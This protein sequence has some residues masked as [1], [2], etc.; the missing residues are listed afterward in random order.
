[1]AASREAHTK[2]YVND[3]YAGLYS[4]VES[5]DKD[6]LARNLGEDGGYLFEYDYPPEAAPYYFEDRGSDP[7]QYVPRPF[8]PQT[9]ETDPRPEFIVDLVQVINQS[10][11]ATFRTAIAEY[12]DLGKFLKHVAVEVFVADYDGFLGQWG[13]NNFNFYRH[14]NQKLFTFIPWDKSQA[15]LGGFTYSIFKNFNDVPS[16]Q[17][18]RLMSRVL[19]YQDLFNLYLDTL[20]DCV[21]SAEDPTGFSDGKGW[22]E[23][24]I[25]REYE[26]IREA[27]LADPDKPFSNAEF[28]QAVSDLGVFSRQRGEQVRREVNNS[29]PR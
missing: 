29:R 6:F 23:H 13:M 16:A 28:E 27:A 19:A 20:L 3:R 26:Q 17:R 22:L 24:E 18:N 4:I 21:T 2:L 11:D 7:A 14:D 5:V 10:S 1:V 25:Q 8:K 9:H 15:F 12:L